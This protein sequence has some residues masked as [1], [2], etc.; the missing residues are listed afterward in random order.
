M[1][2]ILFFVAACLLGSL[3]VAA[4]ENGMPQLY[5]GMIDG[6]LSVTMFLYAKPHD[7]TGEMMYQGIYRYDKNPGTDDWL[8]LE[9]NSNEEK[10]FSMVEV[11]FT[12]LMI[13]QK[14]G[15]TFTGIW[16]HPDGKKQVKVELKKKPFPKEEVDKY[17]EF[18]EQTNHR[19]YD[20]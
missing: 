19:Y 8:L 12:G 13:L 1:Y 3:R 9:I 15:D 14:K 4:Q 11:G 6:K 18:L 20:C 17:L 2:R 16:I 10:Q 7:C 5:T